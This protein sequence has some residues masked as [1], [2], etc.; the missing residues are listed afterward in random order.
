MSLEKDT[1]IQ[2]RTQPGQ[3]IELNFVILLVEAEMQFADY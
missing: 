1:K 3:Y 2:I